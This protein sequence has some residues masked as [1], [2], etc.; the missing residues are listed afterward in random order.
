MAPLDKVSRRFVCQQHRVATC[1]PDRVP[2][3]A[4]SSLAAE[5]ETEEA[6]LGAYVFAGNVARWLPKKYPGLEQVYQISVGF[7][8][9]V[10]EK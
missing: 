3:L 4:V 6:S 1:P 2:R 9:I 5:Q 8:R 10:T 7:T